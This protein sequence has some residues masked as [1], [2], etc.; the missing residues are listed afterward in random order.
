[1]L[2]V[3]IRCTWLEKEEGH[4]LGKALHQPSADASY[5]ASSTNTNPSLCSI[6]HLGIHHNG[7]YKTDR[8]FC[9]TL[10]MIC[11]SPENAPSTEYAFVPHNKPAT[12]YCMF[13]VGHISDTS[14]HTPW[15]YAR[16]STWL[17]GR[18]DRLS[19]WHTHVCSNTREATGMHEFL[20]ILSC[21]SVVLSLC[22]IYY[23]FFQFLYVEK[24]KRN[25]IH[26]QLNES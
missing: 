12:C 19:P 25:F 20:W 11:E 13:L 14:T 5:T 8:T 10:S 18:D 15:Y 16:F 6:F 9:T 21:L 3:F 26:T 4:G 23:L 22:H 24:M 1:M 7:L 17:C 2:C